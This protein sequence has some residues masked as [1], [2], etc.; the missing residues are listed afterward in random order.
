[1][2]SDGPRYAALADARDRDRLRAVELHRRGWEHLRVWTTD[3]FRDPARDVA[4]IL[5]AVGVRQ[6][7]G[8]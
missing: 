2:E 4:R 1:V 8:D 5:D 3:L 6:A 7:P